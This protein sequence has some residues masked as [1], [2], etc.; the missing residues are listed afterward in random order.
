MR[1]QALSKL[2][3]AA[4]I[5]VGGTLTTA[6]TDED[7]A[8]DSRQPPSIPANDV[9]YIDQ[10]VPH[11]ESAIA[12]ADEVIA[13]GSDPEVRAMAED[14][15]ATQQ[16]EIATLTRARAQLTGREAVDPVMDPHS[17]IDMAELAEMSGPELDRAFLRNM[18]P[19][20]AGAVVLSHRAMPS[21]ERDDTRELAEMTVVMQTREMNAMLDMLE[22]LGS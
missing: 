16:E 3:V 8:S 10:L 7:A 15:K 5:A 2:V 11:H 12:M 22:R 17:D 14:M 18:I 4:A 13:R 21:L 1:S 20:H 6:C 9:D 19:H